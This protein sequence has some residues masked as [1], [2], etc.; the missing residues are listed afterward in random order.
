MVYIIGN[1]WC[2]ENGNATGGE[3]GD[4]KQI[5]IDDFIG[6][7]RQQEFYESSKGWYIFRPIS[8]DHA[9]NLAKAMITACNNIHIGYNQNDRYGIIKYGT[10][11]KIDINCDCSSLVRQCIKEATGIDPG[12]F[13][14]S[15]EVAALEK[16][17]LFEKKITYKS[18]TKLYTGDVIVTKTKGHTAILTSALSRIDNKNPYPEPNKNVTS[19]TIANECNL[20]NYIWKGE[21]VKWV[22]WYLCEAGYKKQ[23]DLA[24]G[25]DGICGSTTVK[26][27]KWFQKRYN[28][29]IDGIC[30]KKTRDKMKELF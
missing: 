17:G 4:Q 12:D 8:I 5:N 7:V 16:T 14:T 20:K 19:K 18:D 29:E 24:G 21:E 11:S 1:A 6:E 3:P 26:C 27:I 23:I 2:D 25:I 9:K 22:Q 30:G 13:S 28:L 15:S 10:N